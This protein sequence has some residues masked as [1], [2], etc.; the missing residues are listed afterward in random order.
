MKQINNPGRTGAIFFWCFMHLGVFAFVIWL[1]TRC[2]IVPEFWSGLQRN[3]VI[4]LLLLIINIMDRFR[5]AEMA[6]REFRGLLPNAISQ[7]RQLVDKHR[8]STSA[9]PKEEKDKC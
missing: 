3:S 8:S 6:V 4:L 1:L 7:T 5:T 2:G 9:P